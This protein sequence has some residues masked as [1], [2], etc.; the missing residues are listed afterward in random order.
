[1]QEKARERVF[2]TRN[3]EKR[4]KIFVAYYSI[5]FF[6][7]GLKNKTENLFTEKAVFLFDSTAKKALRHFS[8]FWYFWASYQEV[9][10]F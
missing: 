7:I 2:T 1:L 8:Y 4:M 6:E 9:F 10:F 3:V 5:S